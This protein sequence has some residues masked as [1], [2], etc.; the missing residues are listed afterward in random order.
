MAKDEKKVDPNYFKQEEAEVR[1]Q[2]KPIEVKKVVKGIVI[3]VSA[4][5]GIAVNVGGNG[6]RIRFDPAKHSNLKTGD[7][8]E[9]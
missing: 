7:S 6:Q 4:T 2:L 9:I 1:E 3:S 8:I 5:K